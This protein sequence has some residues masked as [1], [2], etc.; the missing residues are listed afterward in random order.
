MTFSIPI[1]I[2]ALPLLLL[3]VASFFLFRNG[4]T[5]LCIMSTLLAVSAPFI[6]YFIASPNQLST[7]AH[8]LEIDLSAVEGKYSSKIEFRYTHKHKPGELPDV[9]KPFVSGFGTYIH[10]GKKSTRNIKMY[11]PMKFS[12]EI[13]AEDIVLPKDI[14]NLSPQN[15]NFKLI[16]TRP[17]DSSSI[18]WGWAVAPRGS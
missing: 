8:T 15:Y 12:V 13:E 17:I 4:K 7:Y 10:A 5:K 2:Y 14:S 6:I 18:S 9:V 11:Q 3:G 16:G 1:Y